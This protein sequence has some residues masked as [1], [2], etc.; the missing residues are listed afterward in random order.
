MAPQLAH[1]LSAPQSCPLPQPEQ[2]TMTPQLSATLPHLPEQV[3]VMLWLVQLQML[4]LPH[5]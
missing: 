4:L 3:V 2:V 5:V 1:L